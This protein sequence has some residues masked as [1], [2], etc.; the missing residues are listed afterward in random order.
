MLVR[1]KDAAAAKSFYA[2]S[3][4]C[5]ET[6]NFVYEKKYLWSFHNICLLLKKQLKCHTL[7]YLYFLSFLGMYRCVFYLLRHITLKV[8]SAHITQT[9]NYKLDPSCYIYTYNETVACAILNTVHTRSFLKIVTTC[10]LVQEYLFYSKWT[11]K[12]TK[13]KNYKY[14]TGVK[15]IAHVFIVA[16]WGHFQYWIVLGMTGMSP[17]FHSEF[18]GIHS[19][20]TRSINNHKN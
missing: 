10:T 6:Y 11:I 5:I 7:Y 8:T 2:T 14:W 15:N 1:K 17:G 18:H 19:R 3:A 16:V 13:D 12:L 20:G 9:N 4:Q